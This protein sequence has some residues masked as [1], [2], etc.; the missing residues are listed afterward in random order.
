MKTGKKL[1]PLADNI[2]KF[3][4]YASIIFAFFV[5]Y[6]LYKNIARLEKA[7][8]RIDKVQESVDQLKSE[9]QKLEEKIKYAESEEYIEK[10]IRDNLGRAKEGE[11]IVILPDPEI[12][13][14]YAPK[15]E[16]ETDAIETK[17]NWQKWLE[18]FI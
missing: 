10:Q 11:A 14:K 2:R 17:K 7:K 15:V 4:F 9:N 13:K 12:V 8:S 5:F 18:L 16:E 6:S 3:A 1:A